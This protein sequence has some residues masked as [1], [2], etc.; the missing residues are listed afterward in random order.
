MQVIRSTERIAEDF[1]KEISV[2]KECRSPHVVMVRPASLGL[3]VLPVSWRGGAP[4]C[5]L[6]L[7]TC[8]VLFSQKQRCIHLRALSS[9][10]HSIKA[11]AAEAAAAFSSR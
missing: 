7:P 6:L 4:S 9:H 8:S 10:P 3:G 11:S 1:L 5:F 2:L